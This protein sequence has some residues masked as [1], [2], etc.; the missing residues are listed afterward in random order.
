M[1]QLGIDP[2]TASYPK[3]DSGALTVDEVTI[4]VQVNGKVRGK[5]TVPTDSDKDSVQAQA[6]ALPT[7]AKFITGDVKKIIVV[8]NKLVSIVV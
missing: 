7:V 1:A 2:L 6:L 4:V 8:P 5:M 3:V